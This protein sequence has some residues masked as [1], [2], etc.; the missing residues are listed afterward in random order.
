MTY[1]SVMMA[2]QE[3]A[4]VDM[5]S[6]G[7]LDSPQTVQYF[8]VNAVNPGEVSIKWKDV[9]VLTKDPCTEAHLNRS[10]DPPRYEC[11]EYEVRT[12]G[13]DYEIIDRDG[14]NKVSKGDTVRFFLTPS[15][16][17]GKDIAFK[18][19]VT[20]DILYKERLPGT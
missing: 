20:D 18:W 15:S 8:L 1:Y 19:K 2:Q 16:A 17:W 13:V 5:E 14:N 12:E 3:E 9:R 7:S 6:N 10:K 4:V 11:P